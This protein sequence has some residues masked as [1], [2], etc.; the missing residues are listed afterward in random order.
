MFVADP[1]HEIMAIKSGLASKVLHPPL[2]STIMRMPLT[3]T[4]AW[5]KSRLINY[6]KLSYILEQQLA[7]RDEPYIIA[8]DS[9]HSAENLIRQ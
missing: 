7:I 8:Y 5:S 3:C 2:A 1:Y 6:F 9:Q 4:I